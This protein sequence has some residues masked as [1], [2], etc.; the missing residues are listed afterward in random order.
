MCKVVFLIGFGKAGKSIVEKFSSHGFQVTV[1]TPSRQNINLQDLKDTKQKIK[2]FVLEHNSKPDII[3]FNSRN[4]Q[5]NNLDIN[6]LNISNLVASLKVGAIS[7]LSIIQSINEI[8]DDPKYSCQIL[9]AGGSFAKNPNPGQF[10][11]SLTKI[12]LSQIVDLLR[13]IPNTCFKLK[14]LV[15]IGKIGIGKGE[16]SSE[17]I[18]DS[19]FN[20]YGLKEKSLVITPR[21]H[22]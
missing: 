21:S 19:F 11:L 8:N 22:L 9:I 13:E 2:S 12:L 17:R 5:K 20:L 6:D 16:I 10:N 15:I 7:L 1:F 3:I 4:S 14:E 18:A